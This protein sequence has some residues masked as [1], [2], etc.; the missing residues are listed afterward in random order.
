[1]IQSRLGLCMAWIGYFVYNNIKEEMWPFV[2]KV[3]KKVFLCQR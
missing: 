3:N 1:M 2:E